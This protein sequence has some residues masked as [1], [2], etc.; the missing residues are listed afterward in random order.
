MENKIDNLLFFNTKI[1]E[2]DNPKNKKVDNS[3]Y[4]YLLIWSNLINI[5]KRKIKI[6]DWKNKMYKIKNL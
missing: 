5:K 4:E 2:V 3:A 1:K 6:I